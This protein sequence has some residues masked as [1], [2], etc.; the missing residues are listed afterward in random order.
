MSLL[1]SAL[2]W[3][4]MKKKQIQEEI[5]SQTG[6]NKEFLIDTKELPQRKQL[7]ESLIKM[8]ALNNA[9]QNA[10]LGVPRIIY[11]SRTHSQISQ[12]EKS[13]KMSFFVIIWCRN[14][15]FV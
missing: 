1:C 7:V 13:T 3:T 6:V 10:M 9:N 12:G 2:A 14:L 8:G 5:E 15:F 4:Q 11:S